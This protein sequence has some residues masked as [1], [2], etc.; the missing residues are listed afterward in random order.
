MTSER[1]KVAVFALP[2][3]AASLF[4]A[5]GTPPQ[6][7]S[8]RDRI[9]AVN[10]SFQ[11]EDLTSRPWHL[12]LDVTVFDAKGKNP[13]EGTIEVWR[14]GDDRRTSFNFA[15]SS[16]S[17]L[18]SGGKLYESGT[19]SVPYFASVVL[20]H[21]L[22]PG[23]SPEEVVG[24]QPELRRQTFGKDPFDCI[25]LSHKIESVAFAP[26]GLFPTY[27]LKRD[28][29]Y[30]LFSYDYG[31]QLVVFNAIGKF[32]D[33]TLPTALT[34]SEGEITA[35]TAKV[36]ALSTFVPTPS[37]FLPKPSETPAP[38]NLPRIPGGVLAGARLNGVQ[39]IY[40]EG[41]K[42]RHASGTVILHAIIGRDGHIHSLR[43]TTFP[44]PD[45][46]MSAL[47]AVRQWTYKPYLLNGE[48][49]EVDTTITVNFN[50]NP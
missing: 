11:L 19:G 3:L 40:P 15:E 44:D 1:M 42:A 21:V 33:H 12:K 45:L 29:N 14:S 9:D 38:S 50:L 18:E 37:D 25:M 4:H 7:Q 20:Q 23:P 17:E 39:P 5:Q 16:S 31:E 2:L 13:Q 41:A 28:T 30:L 46:V 35:A 32:L 8:P 27:C 36:S 10:G 48:P 6:K 22:H 24:A 49:T 34:I 47:Y 43:P 26:L